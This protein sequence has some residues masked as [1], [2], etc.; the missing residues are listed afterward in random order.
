[1]YKDKEERFTRL[2]LESPDKKIVYELPYNDVNGEDMVHALASIMFSMTFSWDT[3]L[4]SFA[5]YIGEHGW[6]QYEVHRKLED[7]P[8]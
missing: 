3:I 2:V 6:G 8:E 1:M 7:A 5:D 4:A